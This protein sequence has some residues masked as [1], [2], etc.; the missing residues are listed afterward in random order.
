[1]GRQRTFRS[2]VV[3]VLATALVVAACGDDDGG[4]SAE[5]FKFG[6]ILVGPQNDQGWSQAHYEA[7]LYV[8]ERL[9]TASRRD[10]RA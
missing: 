3:L 5:G 9:R 10:D 1:M 8:V 7:G 6:M 4:N 2:V